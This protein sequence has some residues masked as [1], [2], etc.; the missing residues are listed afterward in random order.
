MRSEAL[1]RPGCGACCVA[2]S[3]SSPLPRHPDGKPAGVRCLHLT[4]EFRCDIFGR[5]ERP[6]VC[7]ELKP[8]RE[9]CGANRAD[10]L[11]HLSRLEIETAP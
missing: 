5:P 2:I 1:C 4:P 7:I 8:S 11:A 10:A 6:R 9:M 3:I